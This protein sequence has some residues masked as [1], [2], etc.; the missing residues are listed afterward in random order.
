MLF[1]FILYCQNNFIKIMS[2]LLIF[3]V[4]HIQKTKIILIEYIFKNIDDSFILSDFEARAFKTDQMVLFEFVTTRKTKDTQR[5]K[6][7]VS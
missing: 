7:W 3:Y 2:L 4:Y 5:S 6:F 1:V